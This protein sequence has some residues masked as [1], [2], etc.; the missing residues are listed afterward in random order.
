ME[1]PQFIHLE[2]LTLAPF[3]QPF[4]RK[5]K[6]CIRFAP[7]SDLWNPIFFFWGGKGGNQFVPYL[8]SPIPISTLGWS[9]K[10]TVQWPGQRSNISVGILLFKGIENVWFVGYFCIFCRCNSLYGTPTMF[11]DVLNHPM[12]EKFD[13]S[14]LRT[15][16]EVVILVR[17]CCCTVNASDLLIQDSLFCQ[18]LILQLGFCILR[19]Y[20]RLTVS[21]WG[22]ET[23]Y[24]KAPHAT[25]YGK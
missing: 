19:C 13:V 2:G 14:S 16:Q 17:R 21:Y 9:K 8:C 11:I 23:S 5:S 3:W 15:G 22:Y 12:L 24:N 1:L 7:Y 25:S 6:F 18:Y 20:G 10:N 4:S